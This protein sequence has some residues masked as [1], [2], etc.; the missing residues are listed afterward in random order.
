MLCGASDIKVLKNDFDKIIRSLT[1]TP[2]SFFDGKL[3]YENGKWTTVNSIS[4]DTVEY[5]NFCVFVI[6]KQYGEI[7]TT[8]EWPQA[9]HS[10]NKP[11]IIFVEKNILDSY[12]RHILKNEKLKKF[13]ADIEKK[14]D[15]Y[16]EFELSNFKKKLKENILH[17]IGTILIAYKSKK[18]I[19]TEYVLPAIAFGTFPYLHPDNN[20]D[21]YVRIVVV[22]FGEK[23]RKTII[24]YGGSPS[25]QKYLN[26]YGVVGIMR[27]EK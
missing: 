18:F 8:I 13:F 1:Y 4:T 25:Q 19:T 17:Y 26:N 7:T 27:K 3:R 16:I 2:I 23:Y 6:L 24:H 11:Y 10:D 5:A 15:T 12:K 22:E 21:K 20:V 14:G 9:Y